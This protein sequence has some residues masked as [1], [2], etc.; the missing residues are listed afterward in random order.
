MSASDTHEGPEPSNGRK[1]PGVQGGSENQ[2]RWEPS[3]VDSIVELVRTAI[4]FVRQETADV[5]RGSVV[6]PV[7]RAGAAVA[8]ALVAAFLVCL[9]AGLLVAGLLI[10]AAGLIGWVWALVL[11]GG[12]TAA[13]GALVGV[14]ALGR[15]G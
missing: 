3:L 4:A 1:D 8:L 12:V 15:D 9:G 11:F 6:Q 7:R 10:A 2:Q 5:V 13:L 14:R